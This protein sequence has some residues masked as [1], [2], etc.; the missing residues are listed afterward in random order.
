MEV[1]EFDEIAVD[2]TDMSD[3]GTSEAVSENT[4]ESTAAG[5]EDGA[6]FE[7]LLSVFADAT[8]EHLFVVAGRPEHES[9]GRKVMGI[10]GRGSVGRRLR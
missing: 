1:G 5:E 3:T 6:V 2:D 10:S 7:A 8:E 9:S 4:S